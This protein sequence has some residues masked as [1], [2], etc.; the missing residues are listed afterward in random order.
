MMRGSKLAN[1]L[2][3]ISIGIFAVFG[4]VGELIGERSLKEL[5][6]LERL[7]AIIRSVT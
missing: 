5:F 2:I 7:G 6:V 1:K 3:P 4:G